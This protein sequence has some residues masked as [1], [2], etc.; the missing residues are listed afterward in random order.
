[1]T[2]LTRQ[3]L[4]EK[5]QRMTIK[6][7]PIFGGVMEDEHLCRQLIERCLPGIRIASLEQLATQHTYNGP[8]LA[9]GVRYDV[10]V[11]DDQQRTIVVEV[12]V[13]NEHN[14]PQRLRYYQGAVDQEILEPGDDYGRLKEYP[15]YVIALCDFD[16]YR[17]GRA[18]YQREVRDRARVTAKT[19][20]GRTMVIFNTRASDFTGAAE[21]RTFLDLMR[22]KV[23][24]EDKFIRDVLERVQIVKQDPERKA[25]Y[26]KL[27]YEL[28]RREAEGKVEGK[29]EMAT[30]LIQSMN[31]EGKGKNEIITFLVQMLKLPQRTAE[32]YYSNAMA[33]R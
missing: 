31:D 1:M 10:Y 24:T 7:D 30:T 15:T 8:L 23:D 28:A 11:R 17:Q 32:D 21:I 33:L 5:W 22:G 4:E 6:D 25:A 3:S 27:E 26:M 18:R 2:E 20:D 14:V 19:D 12:Q 9:R 16:Y 29:E 13:K